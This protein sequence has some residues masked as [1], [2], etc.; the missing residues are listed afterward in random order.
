MHSSIIGFAETLRP[1]SLTLKAAMCIWWF[2]VGLTIAGV[3]VR[4]R[5]AL[6]AKEREIAFFMRPRWGRAGSRC[7][8]S[9]AIE[10]FSLERVPSGL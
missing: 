10:S 4:V 1:L 6:I 9:V 7:S 3:W 2:F 5:L 8:P